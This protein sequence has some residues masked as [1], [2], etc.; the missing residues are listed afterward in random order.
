M[1]KHLTFILALLL[2]VNSFAQDSTRRQSIFK[3]RLS[4]DIPIG[5]IT[6]GTGG[7]GL[8]LHKKKHPLTMEEIN[9]LKPSDVN[10]FDRYSIYQHSKAAAIASDVIQITAAVSPALLFIDKDIRKDWK[11]VLPVWIETFALTSSLTM[12]TKEIAKRTRPYVYSDYGNG[13][14]YSKDARA[15]FWSGH[16]AIT[17]SSTFFIAMMY[18]EYHPDSRWR[19]LMWTG[20]AIVPAL[21]GFTRVKAGKHYWTDVLTGYAVGALVG[22]LTPFLHRRE[23]RK[24]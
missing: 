16:T 5:L 14:K 1:K 3:F 6:L 8:I 19:P 15:S 18:N 20:A 24:H 23:F 7:A 13:D 10:K 12:F 21:V 2:L 9:N 11:T 4:V 17:A 22:T